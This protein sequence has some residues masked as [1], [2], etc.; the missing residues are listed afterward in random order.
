MRNRIIRYLKELPSAFSTNE[1]AYYALG[2][3]MEMHLRDK[4]AYKIFYDRKKNMTVH[5]EWNK[6]DIS[7]HRNDKV[8]ALLELKYDF[9][10][11][12]ARRKNPE[13]GGVT[14]RL[15]LDYD[16]CKSYHCP[17]HG[18]L[19]LSC[20]R[21]PIPLKYKNQV[22]ALRSINKY[23]EAIKLP[24]QWR[25]KLKEVV[26]GIF[27]PKRFAIKVGTLD[28]GQCFETNIDLIWF[29]ISTKAK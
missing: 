10:A 14:K 23:A 2:N 24:R 21:S 12:V 28:I 3:R 15:Y 26:E 13:A 6:I 7:V 19:F 9:A 18:I 4:L 17:W 5:R 25:I 11:G 29:L 1:L 8:T 20:P 27:T 16:K 22:R